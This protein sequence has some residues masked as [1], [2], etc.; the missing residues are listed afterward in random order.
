MSKEALLSLI[1][2]EE[3]APLALPPSS[4]IKPRQHG[5]Y[6]GPSGDYCG[7]MR[8]AFEWMALC[9]ATREERR[10]NKRKRGRERKTVGPG[11]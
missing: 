6:I 4:H 8:R 11:C 10:Q 1:I 7:W 5:L 2:R 3:E 9:V